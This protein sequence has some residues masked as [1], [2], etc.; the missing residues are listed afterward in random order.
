[1]V[2]EGIEAIVGYE[3]HEVFGPSILFGIGGIFTELF[4]DISFRLL[5]IKKKD[6]I[7]MVKD[8]KF[9]HMI[10]KGYRN[11]P[12]CSLDMIAELLLAVGD[13]ALDLQEKVSSFDINPVV[14]Y[15][16][17]YRVI[18]FKAALKKDK[19]EKK[20]NR[21]F[22]KDIDK[23]FNAQSVALIGASEV[24]SKIGT[25]IMDSLKNHGYRG[26]IYPINPKYG[27][28]M[29][30]PAHK[31]IL[32]IEDDID[33]LLISISL[34]RIPDILQEADKKN[35]RNVIIIS[36]GGKEIGNK[37][38]EDKIK[39][40]AQVLGVRI[41]GCNCLG[42]FNGYTRLD[43]L[44]TPNACM[45][46]PPAGPISFITQSGTV[47][48]SF[49]ELL[50][51]YGMAKFAS[52]GNR[53]DVD[54]ADLITYLSEDDKTSV[55][56]MYIEGLEKGR[57]FY[58]SARSASKKKPILVYKAG[59]SPEASK[60]ASSHTG[61]LSGTYSLIK[62]AMDQAN[63]ISVDNF[64]SL[65]AS[66]KALSVY[67]RGHGNRVMTVTNGAGAMI[68]ALDRIG[69]KNKLVLAEL[70]QKTKDSL[71]VSL[72]LHATIANP[73]DI[74]GSSLDEHYEQCI[75]ASIEDKN[76]D[77]L[78]VW[79][80]FQVKTITEGMAQI[81]EKYF[82]LNQKPILCGAF[83]KGH[84]WEMG[85]LIEQKGIPIYYSIEETISAAESIAF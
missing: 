55:I 41:M 81:L 76:V 10:E 65:L 25:L 2:K 24:G 9:S 69:S 71:Q 39:K 64:E 78:I 62:G 45:A 77:I 38:I 50:G 20:E 74:S 82:R 30:L 47:G 18:D 34:E 17:D 68:Q 59:R 13:M 4:Q 7:A 42:V 28:V 84:T 35:I 29:G 14:L 43:T 11:I 48:I 22:T 60:A 46:R 44:F 32:E 72:P 37:E 40:T 33:L 21:I 3:D 26:K 83:G 53:I 6:A 66:A 51:D 67:G 15:A 70:S 16:D 61:F 23:F 58:E 1:M 31:S 80:V 56:S 75:G 36:A 85:G 54:E 49:L 12:A 73:I 79:F 57:K 19:T 52:Y 8:L 5:P 27:T 63:I